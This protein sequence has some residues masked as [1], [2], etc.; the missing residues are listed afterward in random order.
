VTPF[1]RL[2]DGLFLTFA[3]GLIREELGRMSDHPLFFGLS[4]SFFLFLNGTRSNYLRA[5]LY[6]FLVMGPP[7]SSKTQGRIGLLFLEAPLPPLD[8]EEV[9]LVPHPAQKSSGRGDIAFQGPVTVII[10][11]LPF[12]RSGGLRVHSRAPYS[13]EALSRNLD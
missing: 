5:L 10:F 13:R 6:R 1:E 8:F 7:F 12:S 3:L 4:V 11:L 2:S 9:A